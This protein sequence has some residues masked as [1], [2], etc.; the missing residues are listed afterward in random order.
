MPTSKRY[1]KLATFYD[2]RVVR[3][4]SHI[5][6]ASLA[7]REKERVQDMIKKAGETSMA[8]EMEEWEEEHE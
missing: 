7:A 1:G 6:Q 4:A 5:T 2:E 3:E 8:A